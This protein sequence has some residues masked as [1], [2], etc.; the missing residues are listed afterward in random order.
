MVGESTYG[1]LVAVGVNHVGITV[2]DDTVAVL[3]NELHVAGAEVEAAFLIF[4]IGLVGH[5]LCVLPDTL[6][7]LTGEVRL[8]EVA[9]NLEAPDVAVGLTFIE[10]VAA[11]AVIV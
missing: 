2:V 11:F 6:V 8:L 9:V 7:V 1:N 3:V 4:K 5:T 10:A